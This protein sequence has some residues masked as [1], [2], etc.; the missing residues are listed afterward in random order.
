MKII[1]ENEVKKI[2]DIKEAFKFIE[3]SYSDYS[4]NKTVTP[5]T[6]S[7]KVNEGMFYSFPSFIKESKIFI[8][9]QATDFRQNKKLCLPSVH[10]YILVFNSK[11]GVLDSI[12]EARYFAA[13][14]TSLSS[15]TGIKNLHDN[16]KKIAILGTGVQGRTHAIVLSRLFPSIEEIRIFSPTEKSRINAT[17]IIKEETD[18]VKI[19]NCETSKQAVEE[20]EVIIC[21]TSS[22]KPVFDA[23]HLKN[24]AL[25]IGV[26]AMKNDQE[27]PAKTIGSATI[28]LD[29]IKNLEMYDE[30]KIAKEEGFNTNILGE[31]GEVI[32]KEKVIL[33]DQTIVFKHHGLPV[34]DAAL[35]ESIISKLK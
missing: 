5:T 1:T 14:R 11:N 33:K 16:P 24:S 32:N 6:S 8:S 23:E 31:I 4:S 25:V 9:K 26:G 30:I 12:I 34:T 15:A 19:I 18:S 17:K 35:A 27:I 29:A 7:M 22:S 10:P 21:A 3:K 28:V 13:I 2:I 20:A